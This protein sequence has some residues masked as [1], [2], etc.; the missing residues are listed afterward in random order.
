MRANVQLGNK[1]AQRCLHFNTVCPCLQLTFSCMTKRQIF[2]IVQIK[3]TSI[4]YIN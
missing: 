2:F 4:F 3:D 1:H